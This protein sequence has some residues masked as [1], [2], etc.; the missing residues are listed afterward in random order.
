MTP[1]LAVAL[2]M[3]LSFLSMLYPLEI[4]AALGRAVR[5]VMNMNW[6]KW[7][8]KASAQ[9]KPVAE[10]DYKYPKSHKVEVT[11]VNPYSV[12]FRVDGGGEV[13]LTFRSGVKPED[14]ITEYINR[15]DE[16]E[17]ERLAEL[18]RVQEEIA[19]RF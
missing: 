7:F 2:L 18:K 9:E 3:V 19:K 8:V 14:A 5:K 11:T 17:A 4:L 12:W 6:T 10:E 1:E 13:H 15:R 16:E